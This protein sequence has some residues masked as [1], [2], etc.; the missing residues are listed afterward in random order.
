RCHKMPQALSKCRRPSHDFTSGRTCGDG[1]KDKKRVRCNRKRFRWQWKTEK[2]NFVP[3]V[4]ETAGV[5]QVED[6]EKEI[7]EMK[8][9]EMPNNTPY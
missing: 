1:L 5:P 9:K 6:W 7:E 8:D 2:A 3:V 4:R